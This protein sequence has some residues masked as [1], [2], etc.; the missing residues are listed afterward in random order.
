MNLQKTTVFATEMMGQIE[1]KAIAAVISEFAKQ[2]TEEY[3]PRQGAV[4][5]Q[6]Q[7]SRHT[8]DCAGGSIVN[9]VYLPPKPVVR[10]QSK[11]NSDEYVEMA[12]KSVRTL[13]DGEGLFKDQA[14][15]HLDSGIYQP[16]Q[17]LY[18]DVPSSPFSLMVLETTFGRILVGYA[19]N[20]MT[21]FLHPKNDIHIAVAKTFAAMFPADTELTRSYEWLLRSEHRVTP[22]RIREIDATIDVLLERSPHPDI[23]AYREYIKS[24]PKNRNYILFTS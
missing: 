19:D 13:T 22:E 3:S 6:G 15:R 21:T 16:A 17:P 12:T 5:I 1:S 2:D 18:V 23:A 4:V 8:N 9:L 10:L 20:H 24:N 11:K 14:N 7:Q